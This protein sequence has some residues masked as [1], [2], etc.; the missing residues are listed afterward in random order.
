MRH[1]QKSFGRSSSTC[2]LLNNSA[3]LVF[4]KVAPATMLLNQ[5]RSPAGSEPFSKHT[6][7]VFLSATLREPV[8]GPGKSLDTGRVR[9][10]SVDLLRGVIMILMRSHPRLLRPGRHKSHRSRA[11]DDRIILHPLD[12]S[13]LRAGLFSAHRHRRPSLLAKAF[14][15]RTVEISFHPRSLADL[16]GADR[17]PL[18]RLPI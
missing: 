13:F 11:N 2:P 15:P 18:P 7:G 3:R 6:V 9:I 4:C 16:P 17:V 10:E 14:L 12:H 1:A 8:S 5:G